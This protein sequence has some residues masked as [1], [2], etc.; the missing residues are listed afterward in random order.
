MNFFGHA[1]VAQRVDDDP[2]FLLGAMAPDLLPLCG[3]VAGVETSPAVGAGQAHHLAV[4]ASFHSNPAFTALQAWAGRAMIDRGLPRGPARGAAHVAIEL[5]LDGQ[6]ATDNRGRDAY[7]RSL[8]AAETTRSPFVW[9]DEPSRGRW[10][11][12]I[13]RLRGGA[14]PDAYRDPNFVADRVVGALGRRPRLAV[15]DTGADILR[16]F[17]PALNLRVQAETSA[18][19]CTVLR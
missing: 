6:L 4:D 13:L 15:S 12:L 7:T 3:A 2:A 18:L 8:T 9:H 1:F 19:T 11:A 14:V 10:R 16:A 5:F 17:L